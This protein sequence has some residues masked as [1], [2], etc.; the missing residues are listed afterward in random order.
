[1][2]G[3]EA[4]K[5]E[6]AAPRVEGQEFNM[7]EYLTNVIDPMTEREWL[8][9]LLSHIR[10]AS[11]RQLEGAEAMILR[12]MSS[13]PRVD[14]EDGREEFE[15]WARTVVADDQ[16]DFTACEEPS[17]GHWFHYL[18]PTTAWAYSAWTA[19]AARERELLQDAYK[20][21]VNYSGH[22]VDKLNKRL[23]AALSE[24]QPEPQ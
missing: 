14:L 10:G 13:T 2:T 22:R 15:K 5:P 12:K 21:T 11:T 17:C 1:M 19:R 16:L 7:D 8:S 9:V 3:V 20:F 24:T 23:K 4:M 18:N 6:P